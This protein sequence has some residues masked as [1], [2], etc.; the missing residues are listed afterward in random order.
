[1]TTPQR[2]A[3]ST[4][5][6][7]LKRRGIAR[8]EVRV[9]REDVPL[10]R[11]VVAALVDPERAPEARALLRQSFGPPPPRGLKALLAAAP[12]EGIELDRPRDHGRA[13]EL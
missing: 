1:M 2:R 3:L 13:V 10:V 4:H 7:R 8:V 11:S 6:R 5:R 9:R 12:L